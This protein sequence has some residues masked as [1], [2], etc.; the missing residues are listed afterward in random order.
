MT[1]SCDSSPI[2]ISIFDNCKSTTPKRVSLTWDELVAEFSDHQRLKDKMVAPLWSPA[3]FKPGSTRAKQNVVSISVLTLDLDKVSQEQLDAQ[4]RRLRN[5]GLRC[6]A[7]TTWSH[8]SAAGKSCYRLLIALSRPVMAREWGAFWKASVRFLEAPADPACCDES[9]GYFVPSAPIDATEVLTHA[10]DGVPLDV[11]EILSHISNDATSFKRPSKTTTNKKTKQKKADDNSP[12]KGRN[13]TLMK[14]AG[15]LRRYGADEDK[16]L[17]RL[18]QL[19]A[20]LFNEPLD[21]DEV[22]RIASSVM[23]YEPSRIY[24]NNEVGNALRLVDSFAEEVRWVPDW[25]TWL[26]WNGVFWSRS[27]A[28]EALYRRAGAVLKTLL[29]ELEIL[30]L[31]VD[32]DDEDHGKGELTEL[33]AHYSR[34]ATQHGFSAMV[35][36]AQTDDRV[37]AKHTIFDADPDVL[38]CANGLV[39]LRT[40]NLI[41]HARERMC[42]QHTATAYVPKAD[43]SDWE[44][45]VLEAMGGDAELAAFLQRVVGYSI[46][47]KT[48][49]HALFFLFGGGCNG[50]STFIETILEALGEYGMAAPPHIL[51][52]RR[53]EPHATELAS[54]WKKRVVVSSE[55][56]EG[57][58]WDS[59]KVK[60]LTGGDA[61]TARRMREDFWTFDPTHKL[62]VT[63]NAKPIVRENSDGFWRRMKLIPFEQSFR[64]REDKKLRERL[65]KNLEGVLAWAVAGA[66]AWYREGLAV[67][68]SITK[69]TLAYREEQDD[70]GRFFDECCDRGPNARCSRE[71]IYDRY[72]TWCEALGD[73]YRL[74]TR[75]FAERMRAE[76][77]REKD[78]GSGNAKKRGWEGVAVRGGTL[79][80]GFTPD[81]RVAAEA[82]G[83]QG[84]RFAGL[85]SCV[86]K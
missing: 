48:D 49:E 33:R 20:S 85:S 29:R 59:T 23:R 76:G 10:F 61:I 57:K 7:H 42:T 26:V 35:R 63:A 8:D 54:L 28:G 60:S 55:F 14:A 58:A 82:A 46:T 21:E 6:I 32:A 13:D 51:A 30:K 22:A 2:E 5:L 79:S 66:S 11:D 3:V 86:V 16:I 50:K 73:T 62:F 53:N 15:L 74:S 84:G 70:V 81:P 68:E 39:D 31:A 12:T 65:R 27:G 83:A 41:A 40:G 34:T 75:N 37:G 43:T 69:A 38:N 80:G 9:R 18:V 1:D 67:P 52:T 36:L 19:N 44:K 78:I 77:F 56:E 47:G 4:Y 45:F 17:D 25:K 24:E 64:G 72:R 71:E